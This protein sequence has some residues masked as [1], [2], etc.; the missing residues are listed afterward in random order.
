[1]SN[2]K[3]IEL[4]LDK[5]NTVSIKTIQELRLLRLFFFRDEIVKET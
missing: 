1:M 2:I 4:H 5:V 3:L